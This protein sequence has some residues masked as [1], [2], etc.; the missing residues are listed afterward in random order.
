VA[1]EGDEWE[2]S[3][4]ATREGMDFERERERE[5]REGGGQNMSK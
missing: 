3:D 4:K 2:V 5:K 1:R